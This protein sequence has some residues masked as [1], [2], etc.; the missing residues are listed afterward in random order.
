MRI[1]SATAALALLAAL[2]SPLALAAKATVMAHV[3]T[4]YEPIAIGPGNTSCSS[5]NVMRECHQLLDQAL[6]VGDPDGVSTSSQLKRDVFGPGNNSGT[7]NFIMTGQANALARPGSLH[8]WVEV[9][10][11]GA[12]GVAASGISGYGYVAIEDQISVRSST[13]ANGTPV[14]LNA[15]LDIEGSGAG[16]LSLIVRGRRNGIFNVG[17]FG[18]SNNASGVPRRIDDIAGSFTAFV[19]ETL[20][21][22]YGLRAATGSSAAQWTEID[23]L[24]GRTSLSSYGNS[25]YLY[26]SSADPAADVFVQGLSGYDYL[27]PSPV[28]EPGTALAML[29]GLGVIGMAALQRRRP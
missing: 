18:D 6:L 28:P 26:F 16:A 12:G 3:E 25:A 5:N 10:V 27:L 1:A 7:P 14:T 19:G 4:V 17:V 21:L 29:L 24:N 22:E 11:T 8:A 23:V 15:L 9:Q 20:N 13:L 2:A